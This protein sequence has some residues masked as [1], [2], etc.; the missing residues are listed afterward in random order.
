MALLDRLPTKDRLK[1][2]GFDI[3]DKCVLCNDSMETR[4]HL[5][6]QCPLAISLWDAVIILNGMRMTSRTWGNHLAWACDAW[7]GRSLLT[8]ILK[9]AWTTFIYTVWEE[10]NKRLFQG[11]SRNF[12]ALLYA[13]KHTVAIQLRG[14]SINRNDSVNTM[15]CNHWGI[16]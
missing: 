5:F 13:V 4:D 11:C 6:I 16:E 1:H 10:R 9:L 7:K 15:L 8:T 2:F 14:R 12:E 3:D